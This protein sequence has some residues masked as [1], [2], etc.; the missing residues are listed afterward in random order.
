[1]GCHE[2]KEGSG[3]RDRACEH[4][5][6]D[7]YCAVAGTSHCVYRTHLDQIGGGQAKLLLQLMTSDLTDLEIN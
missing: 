5:L 7:S 4:T 3:S 6:A 2:G 1:M